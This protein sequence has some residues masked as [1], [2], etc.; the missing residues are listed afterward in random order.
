MKNNVASIYQ[1]NS[2]R[3]KEARLARGY[4]Q[5]KL[6]E[7]LSVSRQSISKYEDG[8]ISPKAEVFNKYVEL[9]KFPMAYFYD[10]NEI[11]K[12]PSNDTAILFRSLATSSKADRE[13]ISIRAEWMKRIVKYF[14]QY[15]EFPQVTITKQRYN[16]RY[17]F[18]EIEDLSIKLRQQ[19]GLGLGPISNLTIL[20]QN[21]G[22]FISRTKISVLKSD[23]CSTWSENRPYIFLT[24]DKNVAVR[25]RFDLAHELGHLV[26][27]HVTENMMNKG[28]LKQIEKEANYFA[29][30]F[31]L[32]RETFGNQIVSTSLDYF[33]QLKKEWKVSIA[34][35]IYRCKELGILS[36][37]QTS[38]LWRQLAARG[39]K[40]N[41]PYDLE[42]LPENPTLLRDAVDILIESGIVTAEEL[43]QKIALP[44]ED[45]CDLCNISSKI[46]NENTVFA[47][48]RLRLMK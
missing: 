1:I 35:M 18:K 7:L 37:N 5:S 41:E 47:Q 40:K 15:L 6:G 28:L 13:K 17:S 2:R 21:K 48:P 12:N 22:C 42:F 27:H 14:S 3:L 39:M 4:S 45:F 26:L 29:G 36:E 46:F 23:G 19:W 10:T 24:A 16:R 33:I 44:K 38:Y 20:L 34:A 25:S 8:I 30:A 32:P 31:L 11:F 9:L 43:L